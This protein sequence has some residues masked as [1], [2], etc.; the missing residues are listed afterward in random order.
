MP[1][2]NFQ[3]SDLFHLLVLTFNTTM[4]WN[5]YI[6]WNA[7]SA[8]WKIGS[9]CCSKQF[10]SP[11][12]LSYLHMS[13]IY[14]RTKYYC[15]VWSGVSSIYLEI[16]EKSNEESSLLSVMT[17]YLGFSYFFTLFCIYFQHLSNVLNRCHVYLAGFHCL[18]S[19]KS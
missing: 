6:E 19:E 5:N 4:K 11:K 7:R 14:S 16:L 13:T 1:D 8:A 15:H 9:R 17:R 10:F 3:G 18:M 2:A 12:S